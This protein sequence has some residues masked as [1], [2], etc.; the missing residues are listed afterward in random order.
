MTAPAPKTRKRDHNEEVRAPAAKK[1]ATT[2]NQQS[3][4]LIPANSWDSRSAAATDDVRTSLRRFGD[5]FLNCP[6]RPQTSKGP[7]SCDDKEGHYI[8]V[9]DD[10]IHRRCKPPF[11]G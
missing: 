11:S 10:M 9:P 4:A 5:Y 7:V 3:Q 8:I 6:F 1:V 2:G